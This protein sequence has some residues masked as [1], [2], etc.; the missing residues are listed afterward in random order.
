L[1]AKQR[2][3][4]A[5]ATAG[6]QG[7]GALATPLATPIVA[8]VSGQGMAQVGY[9]VPSSQRIAPSALDPLRRWGSMHRT[10]STLPQAAYAVQALGI[11]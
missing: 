5:A 11:C 10:A 4:E 3:P 1:K 6:A 8:D 9:F 7:R 2:A